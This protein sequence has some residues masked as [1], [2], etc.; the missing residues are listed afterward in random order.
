MCRRVL[1]ESALEIHEEEIGTRLFGR[2]PDYDK[3]ID[4]IVRVQ[5]SHLR[6]R[7][8]QYF[9]SEGAAEPIVLEV[10]KGSYLPIFRYRSQPALGDPVEPAP[11]PLV[12]SGAPQTPWV[13]PVLAGLCGLLAITC[14]WLAFQPRPQ[15]AAPQDFPNQPS[16]RALY[17]HL[18][19]PNARTSLIVADS[20][21]TF[22]QDALKR[23][24]P[25][26]TYLSGD[27]DLWMKEARRTEK[28]DSRFDSALTMLAF[29]QY[30]SL[31]DLNIASRIQLILTPAQRGRFS[32]SYARN[33]SV[34]AANS[35]NL[36]LLGSDRSDPWVQLFSRYLDFSFVTESSDHVTVYDRKPSPG[37]PA[38]Y[39]LPPL[40]RSG[41]EG[42]SIFALLPGTSPDTR[43]LMIAGTDMEATES[44]GILATSESELAP[45]LKRVWLDPSKPFPYFEMLL[46][47][48][49]LAG[50]PE[51]WS[52]V[53]SRVVTP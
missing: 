4:P 35:E 10:P 11:A 16:L 53:A 5:A 50:A 33:Y 13:I 36:I 45:V 19:S 14:A 46:K 6:K 23:Q 40:S 42:Y 30:T 37:Q 28:L 38:S 29:R 52:L 17:S 2:V 25:L 39:A 7:L 51:S 24:I 20:S 26:D 22:L 49:R 8:A 31:A 44:A 18:F 3:G 21:F 12:P 41:H 1:D 34:R 48:R 9:E 47:T 15:I 32:I 43:V 27:P